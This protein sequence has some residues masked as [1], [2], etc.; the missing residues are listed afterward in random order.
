MRRQRLLFLVNSLEIG[1]AEKQLVTL[2]NHLDPE[3]FEMHLAYLKPGASL[4]P[5]LREERLEAVISVG[6]R[7]FIDLR[8]IARVRRLVKDAAIEA[9]ICTNQYS[10]LYGHLARGARP[11]V[12]LATV[13][14]STLLSAKERAQMLL[15]RR[16]FCRCDLLLYVCESQRPYWRA[17]GLQP[18]AER[19]VYKRIH[20]PR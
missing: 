2:L 19:V 16:L 7:H 10:M 3:R 13:F 1:G 20:T 18:P 5:Q 8:A 14:H 17:R 6:A 11:G 9:I 15:Y 4:R 12:R